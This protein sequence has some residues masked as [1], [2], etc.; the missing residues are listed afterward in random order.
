MRGG[1]CTKFWSKTQSSAVT[2]TAEAELVAMVKG[3]SEAKGVASFIK[4]LTGNLDLSRIPWSE[5]LTM[6]YVGIGILATLTP[7]L[8]GKMCY[9][10]SR[11]PIR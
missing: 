10:L 9:M 4:Y 6:D 7:I 3:T 11:V 1:Q 8:I 2:S 5:N